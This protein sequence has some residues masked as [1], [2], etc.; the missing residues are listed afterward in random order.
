ML[1]MVKVYLGYCF[2]CRRPAMVGEFKLPGWKHVF[3]MCSYCM[4][5]IADKL[6]KEE[7]LVATGM[8]EEATPKVLRS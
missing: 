1:E 3:P 6:V 5:S 7:N 2:N 8:M 4:Q